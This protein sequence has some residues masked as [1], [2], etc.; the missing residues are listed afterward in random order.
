MYIAGVNRAVDTGDTYFAE[1]ETSLA[2]KILRMRE[3]I[4]QK[5]ISNK[6]PLETR[7]NHGRWIVDCP[8]CNNVEFA[9]EDGLFFCSQ[10]GKDES[11]QVIMPNERKQIESILGKRLIINRHWNPIETVEVL[12]TE[13]IKHGIEVI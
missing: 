9:F 2:Q 11:R 3:F 4:K 5:P 6:S 1:L 10:C 7:V 13:N 12:L 8:N